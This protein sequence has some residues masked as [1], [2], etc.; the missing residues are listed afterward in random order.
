MPETSGTISCSTCG[1]SY[2]WKAQYAG[3]TL[4]CRCGSSL[5]AP[6]GAFEQTDLLRQAQGA[7]IPDARQDDEFDRIVASAEY[8]LATD[9]PPTATAPQLARPAAD[10]LVVFVPGKKPGL[11][12]AEDYLPEEPRKKSGVQH[13][14]PWR[15][16]YIPIALIGGGIVGS[17]VLAG[18]LNFSHLIY[19]VS[20]VVVECLINIVVAYVGITSAAKLLDLGLG[21]MRSAVLKIGAIA[22][23]SGTATDALMTQATWM[24]L[25]CSMVINTVAMGALFEAEVQEVAMGAGILWICKLLSLLMVMG[26]NVSCG[27]TFFRN[28]W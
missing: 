9:A 16:Y 27:G 11:G 21:D 2:R 24:A 20:F 13:L 1:K 3:R 17:C 6:T 12:S 28:M 26:I 23:M 18:A 4:R 10:K 7:D 22:L 8:D 15:E 14:S 25:A 19:G 5:L